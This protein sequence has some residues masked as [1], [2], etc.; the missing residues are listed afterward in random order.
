MLA[1][2]WEYQA[3][4]EGGPSGAAA[5]GTL[6]IPQKLSRCPVCAERVRGYRWHHTAARRWGPTRAPPGC[7][8]P[9]CGL[10]AGWAVRRDG[11][12]VA[13]P[14]RLDLESIRLSAGTRSPEG[15]RCARRLRS[16]PG[17]GRSRET[18]CLLLVAAAQVPTDPADS[19]LV[20][21]A[22]G[23]KLSPG[24][25]VCSREFIGLTCLLLVDFGSLMPF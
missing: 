4:L 25:H 1:R 9:E 19:R 13:G 7:G 3:S 20:T 10:A 11:A 24:S 5:V 17:V 14:A 12:R 23:P 16:L 6:A 21:L 22:S 15:T 8:G 18:G 2:N